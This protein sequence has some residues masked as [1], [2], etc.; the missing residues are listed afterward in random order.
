MDRITTIGVL[1]PGEMGSVVAAAALEDVQTLAPLIAASQVILSICPPHAA[2]DLARLVMARPFAGI[3]V[4]ANAVSPVTGREIGKIVTDAG[5]TF[6][7][8]GIIGP[9][10]VKPGTTR[11]YLSG[12]EA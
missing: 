2:V 9:P 3:Y 12:A 7:D 8:G 11:L 4:D 6:V 1:H 10:P 5:A